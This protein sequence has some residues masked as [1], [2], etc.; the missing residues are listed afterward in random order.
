MTAAEIQ[1]SVAPMLLEPLPDLGYEKLRNYIDLL[2]R[3]NA[4]IN[5]TA[6]RDPGLLVKLH[7]GECLR[8]AQLIPAEVATVLDFGSG[9]GLPGIPIQIA[10]PELSLLLAE[11]QAKKAS[12]LRESVRA[13]ALAN[14]E[15]YSGRVEDLPAGRV[16]DLVAMR[17]VDKMDRA[18]AGAESRIGRFCMVLTSKTEEKAVLDC[19][20]AMQWIAH[21]VPGTEQRIILT[22]KK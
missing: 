14:A 11:S 20:P 5:L 7:L 18:L 17:A 8:A 19:L 2:Y 3:W 12:F 4:R 6:V 13:L 10:R 22:G 1:Q 15:V 9:A 21:S 16:F